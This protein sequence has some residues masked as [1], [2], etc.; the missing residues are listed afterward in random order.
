MVAER[1]GTPN[2]FRE[3]AGGS[4][5]VVVKKGISIRD[6]RSTTR[7][8]DPA[9]HLDQ[10]KLEGTDGLD[11]ENVPLILRDDGPQCATSR[12]SGSYED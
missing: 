8:N 12:R 2:G 4:P 9:T 1:G 11:G 3:V 7:S 10:T 5:T 6:E